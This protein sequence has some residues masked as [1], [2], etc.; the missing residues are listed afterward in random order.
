M[1]EMCTRFFLCKK[2]LLFRIDLTNRLQYVESVKCIVLFGGYFFFGMEEFYS[3]KE[4][5]LKKTLL[6]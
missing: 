6:L 2:M 4:K 5:T 3:Y 1:C